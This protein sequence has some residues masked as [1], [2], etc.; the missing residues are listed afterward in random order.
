MNINLFSKELKRN[1]KTLLIWMGISSLFTI[2]VT[3]FYP[4]I[5]SMGEGL[6]MIMSTLPPQI[7]K[8]MG[9]DISTWSSIMGFYSTYY[10]IYIIILISIFTTY[11]ATQIISKE[12]R[13]STSEFLLTKPISRKSVFT[14][15]ILALASLSMIIFLTQVAVAYVGV[16]LF[17]QKPVLWSLFFRLHLEGVLL[18]GIF[19]G[20][21]LVVSQFTNPKRS[22]IGLVIGLTFGTNL[23]SALSKLTPSTEWLGYISPFNYLELSASNPEETI[24]LIIAAIFFIIIVLTVVVAGKKFIL[25][26]IGT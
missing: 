10:K 5:S 8:A 9:M 2:V 16:I 14:T 17:S 3:A 22:L 13:E 15:K 6:N 23:L 26:D 12:E 19:T 20:F 25:R 1:R 4:T 7:T 21:G 24:N 11:T 18:M